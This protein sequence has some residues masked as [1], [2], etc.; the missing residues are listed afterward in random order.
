MSALSA[1]TEVCAL[2]LRSLVQ[3]FTTAL[4]RDTCNQSGDTLDMETNDYCSRSSARLQLSTSCE[5]LCSYFMCV[6]SPNEAIVGNACPC[7][8]AS[9]S[10]IVMSV[11]PFQVS[12]VSPMCQP[13]LRKNSPCLRRRILWKR[14]AVH[15]LYLPLHDW[16]LHISRLGASWCYVIVTIV[17]VS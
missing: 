11:V 6:T 3:S 10:L 1:M 7:I 5:S 14:A 9:H 15:V 4:F 2:A 17:P 12:T 8:L 13:D 16:R